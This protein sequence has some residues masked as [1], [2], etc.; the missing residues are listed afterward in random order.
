[1]MQPA[2]GGQGD[3]ASC[4][5]RRDGSRL[6]RILLDREVRARVVE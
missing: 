1:M 5:D 4:L 2:D 6:R 3:D